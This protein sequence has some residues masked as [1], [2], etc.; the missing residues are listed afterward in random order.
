MRSIAIANQKGGV[1][2]TT[3]SV[4]L[5]VAL[6]RLRKKVCLIDLDPQAHATLHVGVSPTSAPC[7][8]YDV[9]V[10]DQPLAAALVQA[11]ENLWVVPSH[12]D[13]SVAEMALAGRSGRESILRERLKS[14]AG[15]NSVSHPLT[16]TED[17]KEQSQFDYII[18][19]CPPS[20]GLLSLNA[21]AA[22]DEV[23]LP[24]QPHFLALHGLSKLLET[25]ELSAE[26]INPRLRL[27]GVALC[28]Y[29][30]GT[31]LAAE[32]GRDVE[33]FFAEVEKGHPAWKDARVFQ[34]KIRR[35]IRLAEAP[36]FGQSI[37]EYANDSNGASDYHNLAAE[38]DAA[39]LPKF[40]PEGTCEVDR[41]A[42]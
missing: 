15:W 32:V 27:L 6:S 19:D 24:L 37:F 28:L 12:L 41:I 26:H 35:N 29:E 16:S 36:S 38:V 8:A 11:Q 13:L 30:A 22:V 33:A 18:I 9:L 17:D 40:Q 23:L 34:T 25:I 1:G 31:R 3:T 5:A 39:V 14:D 4:N 7:T 21:M 20:L 10:N 42:A 2:K